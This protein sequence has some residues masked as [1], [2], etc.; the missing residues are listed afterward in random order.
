MTDALR[1]SLIL[2]TAYIGGSLGKKFGYPRVIGQ[3]VVCML[4]GITAIRETLLTTQV[5]S[6][7]QTMSQFGVILLLFLT[8]FEID[9]T[10]IRKSA[11]EAIVISVLGA[12]VPFCIGMIVGYMLGFDRVTSLVLGM[13]LSVTAEGTT[14]ALLAEMN[15]IKTKVG[16]I[17]LEVG[18]LDDIFEVLFLTTVIFLSQGTADIGNTLTAIPLRIIVFVLV[19]LLAVRYIPRFVQFLEKNHDGVGLFSGTI[20]IMLIAAIASEYAGLGS[21]IGAFIAGMLMQKSF[22]QRKDRAEEERLLHILS[23]GLVIPFFFAFIG[24]NMQFGTLFEAPLITLVI[25]TAALFGKIGGTLLAYPFTKLSFKQLHLIG[26]GLNSRG[27][28]ELVIAQIAVS[29]G[30]I[31]SQLYSIIVF[32][33]IT[34]TVLFPFVIRSM[35]A[36]DPKI[37]TR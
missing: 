17:L 27:V 14:A 35:V 16:S 19:L 26:W 7:V 32:V 21:L 13:C 6:V 9:L 29:H 31:T 15:M 24:L 28:M 20:G 5:D 12:L 36:S 11:V 23:F 18:I 37:M 10:Q 34:T 2:F 4:F 22:L 1:L 30:L 8:G 33:A 3:L 25:V